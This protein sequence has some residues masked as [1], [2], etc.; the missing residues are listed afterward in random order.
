LDTN[1][2]KLNE[3]ER[4]IISDRISG[5]AVCDTP[6]NQLSLMAEVAI[7]K[8][9]AICGFTLT[10]SEKFADILNEELLIFLKDFGYST[11]SFD[12]IISAFRLNAKGWY[13]MQSGDT[14]PTV[15]PYSTFFSI[16]YAGQVLKY[17]MQYRNALDSKLINDLVYNNGNPANK[18]H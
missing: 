3:F 7:L 14:Q 8:I 13:R 9:S 5:V 2:L 12:E 17:Y 1:S 15:L 16:N 10:T 11:L 18:Y 6:E 4:K